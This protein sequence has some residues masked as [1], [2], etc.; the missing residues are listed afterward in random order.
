M[1]AFL[2]AM[3]MYPEVQKKAQEEL[4][5]V[6]GP[7]RLPNFDDRAALPYVGALLKELM[8]WHVVTPISVPH[9][10]VADDEYRG[11]Y[12]PGET[13]VVVNVW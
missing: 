9:R 5:R 1:Q 12:I 10:A 2:L 7:D 4:D 13:V 3:A 8:R 6:V 11:W